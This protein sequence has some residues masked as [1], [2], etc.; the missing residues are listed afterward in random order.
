M[1]KHRRV[2]L[3]DTCRHGQDTKATARRRQD[4]HLCFQLVAETKVSTSHIYGAPHSKGSTH[5]NQPKTLLS[6]GNEKDS[7]PLVPRHR[8]PNDN[9]PALR[10]RKCQLT[11]A[12]R[13]YSKK[14]VHFAC[15]REGNLHFGFH[16]SAL[17][18]LKHTATSRPTEAI[19]ARC[20]ALR[21]QM[22]DSAYSS[23][24][25]TLQILS[26]LCISTENGMRVVR[27]ALALSSM[28]AAVSCC[29][30]SGRNQCTETPSCSVV[31]AS[32]LSTCSSVKV[33]CMK[34]E[35][36]C[37]LHYWAHQYVAMERA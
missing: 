11:L 16:V 28:V 30:I 7:N 15:K 8:R 37:N 5:E 10:R 26:L 20:N 9:H 17:E 4:I 22:G 13:M 25:S 1:G 21:E 2:A 24:T 18:H 14:V 34:R 19:R 31:P 36:L 32:V 12:L 33:R 35:C 6:N 29:P 3:N 27:L 23:L